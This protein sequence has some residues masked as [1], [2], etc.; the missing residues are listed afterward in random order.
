M[1]K[2]A[3]KFALLAFVALGTIGSVLAGQPATSSDQGSS[4][5]LLWKVTSPHRTLFLAGEVLVLSPK[6][7]PLPDAMTRAFS[8]SKKLVTEGDQAAKDPA[9]V[10]QL[11]RKLGVLPPD[12]S[13]S[14]LLTD[15]QLTNVKQAATAFAL[16]FGNITHLQPWLAFLVL[17]N[18]ADAKY[19]ID[20]KQQLGPYLYA[21]AKQRQMRVSAFESAP[22]QLK[23]FAAIPAE[24]QATWLSMVAKE[25]VKL[26]D[27]KATIVRAWR[28]GDTAQLARMS[29]QRFA[30]HP[31]IYKLLVA[32]RNKRWAKA[33]NKLLVTDGDPAFVVVGAGHF[34][35]PS[36]LL[37]LLR[38]GGFTVTQL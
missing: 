14:S 1:T 21:K 37:E 27:T 26:P 15:D 18:A 23:M 28:T 35:G 3:C 11:I 34:F 10:Q 19:G 33:L 24:E 16:P 4:K 7:Y 9:Q 36:N 13:L 5:T 29:H 8:Q 25:L 32:D 38:A 12:K 31:K 22:D 17:R 20:P 6:D 30:G 2:S